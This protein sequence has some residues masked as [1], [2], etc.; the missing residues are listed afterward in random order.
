MRIESQ[1]KYLQAILQKAQ[2]SLSVDR[3]GP[4]NLEVAK[5]QLTDFNLALSSFMENINEADQK[6]G[7]I[8]MSGVF[9]RENNSCFKAYQKEKTEEASEDTKLKETIHFDLNTKGGGCDFV[10]PN[11]LELEPNMLSFRR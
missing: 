6:S 4:G 10:G 8:E 3:N 9:R 2:E 5:A 1:G 11:G 7:I